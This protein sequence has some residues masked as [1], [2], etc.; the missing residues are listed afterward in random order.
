MTRS[1]NCPSGSE[2]HVIIAHGSPEPTCCHPLRGIAAGRSIR[3]VGVVA[4][5]CNPSGGSGLSTT[6]APEF[7]SRLVWLTNPVRH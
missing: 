1:V 4:P 2:A 7:E 3:M 5:G 6:I